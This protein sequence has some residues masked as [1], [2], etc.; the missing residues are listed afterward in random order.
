MLNF[1]FVVAAASEILP[2]ASRV[3]GFLDVL[4]SVLLSQHI[5]QF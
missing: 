1:S 3:L 5:P 4:G 2:H